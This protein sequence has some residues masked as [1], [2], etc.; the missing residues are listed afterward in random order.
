MRPDCR[1]NLR[2]VQAIDHQPCLGQARQ[3]RPFIPARRLSPDRNGPEPL[4]SS[5]QRPQPGRIIDD[6]EAAVAAPDMY[7]QP[8][9]GNVKADK[10]PILCHAPSTLACVRARAPVQLFGVMKKRTGP[11]LITVSMGPVGVIA[12]RSR[13]HLSTNH[14]DKSGDGG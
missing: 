10:H 6:A 5:K 3:R 9:L 8:A 13:S 4:P 14:A 11:S 2:R 7:V 12:L 1:S